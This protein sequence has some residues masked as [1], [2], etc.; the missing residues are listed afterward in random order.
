MTVLLAHQAVANPNTVVGAAVTVPNITV[1]A[2]TLTQHRV[3][4]IRIEAYHAFNQATANDDPQS[5]LIQT[6]LSISGNADWVTVVEFVPAS[7]TPSNEVCTANEAQ[8]DKAI[9]VAATAGFVAG[10]L[11]YLRDTVATDSEWAYVENVVLNT[12]VDLVDGL[13]TAH[14]LTTTTI[15]GNAEKFVAKISVKGVERIRCVYQNEGGTAADTHVQ[16]EY[17][18]ITTD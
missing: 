11:I 10:D 18:L 8:G 2:D 12:T 16:V 14:A 4:E 6:S 15:F 9:D 3:D 7:G 17:V 13:T 5:I 1:D